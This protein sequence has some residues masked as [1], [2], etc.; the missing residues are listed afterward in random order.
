VI[1]LGLS[2]A[3]Q[4]ALRAAVSQTHQVKVRA[5]VQDL[6]GSTISDLTPHFTDGQVNVDTAQAGTDA[7]GITRSATLTLND[8]SKALPFHSSHPSDS[9]L[10][11]DRMVHVVYDVYVPELADWIPIPV[12][13]GPVTK[14]SRDGDAVNVEAQGKEAGALG[15]AW[16][17]L[18]LH[19]GMKKTDAIAT[20]LDWRVGERHYS[21][22][23]LPNRLPKSISMHRHTKPWAIALHIAHSM[24][25]QLFYDGAGMCRLRHRPNT[26]GFTFSGEKHVVS[27]PQI[28]YGGEIIN[29][30]DV[31]G[32]NPKGPKSFVY[33]TAIAPANH[34]LSPQKLGRTNKQGSLV[35]LYLL[36][37]GDVIRNDALKTRAEA[38]N[39]ADKRLHDALLQAVDVSFDSVPVPFLEQADMCQLVTDELAVTFRLTQFSLPFSAASAAPMTVNY[40]KSVSAKAKAR[41]KK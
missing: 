3:G 20:I 17:P 2:A 24:G 9:A 14:V 30:V 33:A 21:I 38:Q 19:K 37:G 7:V 18:T 10:Y 41:N 35:P 40:K 11:R 29:T 39:F 31:L 32:G 15:A 16:R 4:R 36:P 23:D 25:M 8:P 5:S 22:P 13:T 28:D 26:N 34:P 12:F 27:R 6:D 1:P